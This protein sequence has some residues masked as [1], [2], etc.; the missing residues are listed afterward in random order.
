M[1]SQ[2]QATDSLIVRDLN[3]ACYISAVTDRMAKLSYDDHDNLNYV[4]SHSDEV[5]S[6]YDKYKIAL[7]NKSELMADTVKMNTYRNK[8]DSEQIVSK[9]NYYRLKRFESINSH[10]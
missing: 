6:C 8:Y 3:A 9:E 10:Y 1:R 4:F 7:D 2:S 5:L